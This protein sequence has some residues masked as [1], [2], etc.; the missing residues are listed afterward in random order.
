[1]T[2]RKPRILFTQNPNP[3]IGPT[4]ANEQWLVPFWV[5]AEI[6]G[7]GL[8]R[9]NASYL[10]WR[11]GQGPHHDGGTQYL[12]EGTRAEEVWHQSAHIEATPAPIIIVPAHGHFT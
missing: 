4:F 12:L 2:Q 1:M 11:E 10:Q 6:P 9:I 5:H 3:N 8:K 7:L